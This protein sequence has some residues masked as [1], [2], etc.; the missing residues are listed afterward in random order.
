MNQ[1]TKMAFNA[2]PI[3]LRKTLLSVRELIFTVAKTE[4]AGPLEETLKWG[5]PAYLTVLRGGTTIRLEKGL[6]DGIAAVRVHC[7]TPIVRSFKKIYG[8]QFQYDGDRGLLL[9]IYKPLPEK[10]VSD[11]IA[12]ALT[13]HARK[14]KR[15]ERRSSPF[16]SK[17]NQY[18]VSGFRK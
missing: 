13:Y 9:D 4:N 17:K 8:D 11:F 7:Q 18:R 1:E 2:Y 5:S 16:S 12:L 3:D 6:E 15:L 10:A 14:K